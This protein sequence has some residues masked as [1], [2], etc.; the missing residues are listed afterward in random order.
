MPHLPVD[1]RPDRTHPAAPGDEGAPRA[2]ST[3][4]AQAAADPERGVPAD[5]A[6]STTPTTDGADEGAPPAYPL[7]VC[8]RPDERPEVLER[9]RARRRDRRTGLIA[10]IVVTIACWAVIAAAVGF[11]T[12]M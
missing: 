3:S 5:P 7:D 12:T 11:V 1:P 6:A 8:P 10:L 2:G 9:E 4:G